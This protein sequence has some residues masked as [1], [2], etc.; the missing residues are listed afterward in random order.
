M[1]ILRNFLGAGGQAE[2]DDADAGPH[3]RPVHVCPL[4][5][6]HH[7]PNREL[8]QVGVW[9]FCNHCSCSMNG[10]VL[11]LCFVLF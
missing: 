5:R 9:C 7:R 2:N 8:S 4:H 1:K 3:P 10:S 11:G 6:D